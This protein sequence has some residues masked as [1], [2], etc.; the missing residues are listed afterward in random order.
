MTFNRLILKPCLNCNKCAQM[1]NVVFEVLLFFLLSFFALPTQI[2]NFY[3]YCFYKVE[4]YIL[5]IP[6]LYL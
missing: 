1:V 6:F 4:M 3:S 2:Y 5:D